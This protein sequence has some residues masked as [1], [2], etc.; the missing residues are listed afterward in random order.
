MATYNGGSSGASIYIYYKVNGGAVQNTQLS[1]GGTLSVP[2]G[3]SLQ[4]VGLQPV[5]SNQSEWVITDAGCPNLI[6][7]DPMVTVSRLTAYPGG[8]DC[9]GS[10]LLTAS[11][12]GLDNYA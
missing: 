7:N 5:G 3:S 8:S 4:I 6:E 12:S 9:T 11:V 2:T 1:N 10:I